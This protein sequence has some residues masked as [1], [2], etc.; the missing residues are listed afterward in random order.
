MAR[1]KAD[2]GVIAW[3]LMV[4]VMVVFAIVHWVL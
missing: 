3:A 1:E 2:A 4:L